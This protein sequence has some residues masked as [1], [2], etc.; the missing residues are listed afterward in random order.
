ML[1][2]TNCPTQTYYQ[3]TV[4]IT[5]LY[6]LEI[7]TK[8][9]F[10]DEY[11]TLKH[12]GYDKMIESNQILAVNDLKAQSKSNIQFTAIGS[13][14]AGEIESSVDLKD[15]SNGSLI[16]ISKL[17]ELSGSHKMYKVQN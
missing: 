11:C 15:I 16:F 5:K 1:K 10:S 12:P 4:N 3:A 9:R 2:N 6:I 7:N 17:Q 13:T 8:N 14:D